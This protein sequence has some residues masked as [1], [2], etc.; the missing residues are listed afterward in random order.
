VSGNA[1]Y[2]QNELIDMGNESG[3]QIYQSAGAT[4]VGDFVKGE[5]GEVFPFF[6]GYKVGGILQ[7]EAEAAEYN[8]TY[9]QHAEPGDVRFIDLN[10]DNQINDADRTKIGKGMPDWTFGLNINAGWRNFDL[11]MF[12]QGSYGNDIFDYSQRGD[13]PAMNRPSWVLERWVGEGT[14]NWIPRVTRENPNGNWRSSELYIKDGSYVRL[15]NIQLGYSLPQNILRGAAIERLRL[16]V[17]AENLLTLTD[18]DGFDPEI[19]SGDYTTIGIDRGIYPQART[20][21]VG[22][23]ITF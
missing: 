22:A 2:L 10:K 9:G 6:Y 13:I 17:S 4:G 7:N 5:N 16:Y 3:E 15:K 1:S 11:S 18:Y 20:I 12:F 23:N 8:E 21:S 14:S 19:A